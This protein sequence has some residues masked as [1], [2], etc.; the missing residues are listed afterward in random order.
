VKNPIET[1][2]FEWPEDDMHMVRHDAPGVER[3]STIGEVVKVLGNS[4]RELRASEVTRA[5]LDVQFVVEPDGEGLLD[6]EALDGVGLP[7]STGDFTFHLFLLAQESM[8]DFDG[9]GVV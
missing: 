6:I 8:P 4:I 9:Q 3:V 7:E 2:A 1:F 5:A